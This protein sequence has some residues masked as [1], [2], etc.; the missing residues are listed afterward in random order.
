MAKT[1]LNLLEE[2]EKEYIN[3]SN[4]DLKF[5][6]YGEYCQR[7]NKIT[8]KQKRNTEKME[9]LVFDLYCENEDYLMALKIIENIEEFRNNEENCKELKKVEDNFRSEQ[10]RFEDQKK[11]SFEDLKSKLVVIL[12]EIQKVDEEF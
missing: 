8:K 6:K 10:G 2:E 7:G 5:D 3:Y 9:D 1:V 11:Q 4:A 12:Q